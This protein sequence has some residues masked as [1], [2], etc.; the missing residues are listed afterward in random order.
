MGWPG[1]VLLEDKAW[2][3]ASISTVGLFFTHMTIVIHIVIQG[4]W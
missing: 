2:S 4:T 3:Q 1:K